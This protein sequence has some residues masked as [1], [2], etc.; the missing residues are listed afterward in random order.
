MIFAF[1]AVYLTQRYHILTF[2][3]YLLLEN[4]KFMKH[5]LYFVL[6][7]LLV[8][9]IQAQVTSISSIRVGATTFTGLSLIAE[10]N[11]YGAPEMIFQPTLS[12]SA[13]I[14]ANI[15]WYENLG[16]QLEASYAFQ[17]QEYYDVLSLKEVKKSLSLNYLQMPIMFRYTF[18]DYSINQDMPN[19]F[20]VVGP[21]FSFLQNAKLTYNIDGS[22]VGFTEFHDIIFNPLKERHPAY[23]TDID[24]FNKTD[25]SL[26]CGFGAEFELSDY[27]TLMAD[28]R[29]TWGISD[30][31]GRVWRFPDLRN[32]YTAS[33][34]YTWGLKLA[35]LVTVW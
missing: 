14:A 23:T 7:F 31:N 11:N 16:L 1:M 22:D 27:L 21:Q 18:T 2:S 5:V 29:L 17:G 34:N 28:S 6:S 32:N 13:G 9:T 33:H 4:F 8:G 12:Y 24:L 26:A 3:N 30:I 35:L 25:L 15:N 19:L 10:Q 20:F